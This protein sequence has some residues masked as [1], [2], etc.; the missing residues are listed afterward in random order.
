MHAQ[1][2][3]LPQRVLDLI[4][5]R[6]SSMSLRQR[7]IADYILGNPETFWFQSIQELAKNAGVSHATVVRFC[8]IIG[9]KGF[10]EFIRDVQ[11]IMQTEITIANKFSPLLIDEEPEPKKSSSLRRLLR[12]E[13]E[14]L[15]ALTKNV[16][17]QDIS[18]CVDMMEKANAIYILARMSSYPIAMLFYDTL[19]KACSKCYL[20][21]EHTLQSTAI[22]KQM[23]EHS[24]LFSIAYTRYAMDTVRFTELAASTGCRIVCITNSLVSPL[25][26]L[27]HLKF[28]VPVT[29]FAFADLFAAQVTLVS[30]ISLEYG[31]R[32]M[33]RTEKSLDQFSRIMIQGNFVQH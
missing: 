1:Q 6:T 22:L 14:S 21:P 11:K 29:S 8:Q 23:N 5:A 18:T 24:L 15:E 26:P 13:L 16:S 27:S 3:L 2:A 17:E 28:I 10:G 12:I 33:A 30:A 4:R 9:Y 25:V 20:V 19:M 31:R 7:G 32:S